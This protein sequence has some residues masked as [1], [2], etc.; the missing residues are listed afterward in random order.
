[1][2]RQLLRL[3]FEVKFV[4]SR[5]K[6][7]YFNVEMKWVKRVSGQWLSFN[8]EEELSSLANSE[9]AG[10]VVLAKTHLAVIVTE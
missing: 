2:M 6:V 7:T 4:Q 9:D 5:G 10:N 8:G 3:G 1:M